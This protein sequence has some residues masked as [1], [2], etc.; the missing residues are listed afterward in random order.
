LTLTGLRRRHIA[1]FGK[2]HV[3]NRCC[4]SRRDEAIVLRRTPTKRA[5]G[6]CGIYNDEQGLRALQRFAAAS[7]N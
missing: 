6:R 5:M 1:S 2:R 4:T 7:H 3:S